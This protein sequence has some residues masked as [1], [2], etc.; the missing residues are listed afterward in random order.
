MVSKPQNTNGEGSLNEGTE[1]T[2]QV[3][4]CIFIVDHIF[5]VNARSIKPSLASAGGRGYISDTDALSKRQR[6]PSF[7][8][9]HPAY[10][11]KR[12]IMPDKNFKH[13]KITSVSMFL[14][15]FPVLL[16]FVSA[17][18][19]GAATGTESVIFLHHSTG[20]NVFYGGD[21]SD[22]FAAYNSANGTSYQITERAYPND[23]YPWENYPYDYWNLWAHGAC[24]SQPG[25][26]C[27]NT[28]AAAYN[29]VIFKHC[30]PGADVQADTGSPNIASGR[31]S[32]ENYKL[33]YRA[34]R[35]LMDGSP[36]TKFIVWTLAPLHRLATDPETAARAKTFV[37]YVKNDWL[38]E[39]GPHP[40]IFIFDFW[41]YAAEDDPSPAHGE[42]NSLRYDYEDSHSG[43]DSH[44]N[45][46][47][48]EHIGPLF[49][50]FIIN[51]IEGHGILGDVNADS[52]LDL[53]D[54][55]LSLQVVAGKIGFTV[56]PK[57]SVNTDTRIGME[58]AIFVMHEL[59][60]N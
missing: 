21:V 40:N 28:L 53:A 5:S 16:L 7:Q 23:P 3:R 4:C 49:A 46:L 36:E 44:P 19:A 51:T 31:K 8:A 55:I 47:A 27:L 34:L 15:L 13:Y 43:S 30:F 11:S 2:K 48:N 32:L 33:Q 42:V 59:A 17:S 56:D 29:V 20:G 50:Q 26:E 14:R 9:E 45:T 37:D 6:K 54:A 12:N 35:A 57:A 38:T 25:K 60:G 41:G 52:S 39:D 10:I 24:T 58:E 1:I 18:I 22:W